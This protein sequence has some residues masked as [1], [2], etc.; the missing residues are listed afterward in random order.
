M[1]REEWLQVRNNDKVPIS[2]LFEFYKEKSGIIT[3]LP[4]FKQYFEGC[5]NNPLRTG[6]KRVD[7]GTAWNAAREYYDEKFGI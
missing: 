6:M 5:I 2:L 7:Y 1:T 4:T 3:D